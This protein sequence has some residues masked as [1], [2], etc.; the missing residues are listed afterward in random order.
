MEMHSDL[1][2][3]FAKR[4]EE[5]GQQRKEALASQRAKPPM[6]Q[7]RAMQSTRKGFRFC[8][9]DA[10]ANL[11]V[12]VPVF[13]DSNDNGTLKKEISLVQGGSYTQPGE[14]LLKI[15]TSPAQPVPRRTLLDEKNSATGKYLLRLK[16]TELVTE[17]QDGF[18]LSS[19]FKPWMLTGVQTTSSKFKYMSSGRDDFRQVHKQAGGLPSAR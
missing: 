5:R 17:D 12:T 6:A 9:G 15:W 10:V 8:H 14:L 19:T 11:K 4:Q 2:R 1:K 3:R 13:G 16:K 18:R 7:I